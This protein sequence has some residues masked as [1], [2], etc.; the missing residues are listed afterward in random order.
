MKQLHLAH[1]FFTLFLFFSNDASSQSKLPNEFRFPKE[2]KLIKGERGSDADDQYSNGKYI[3]DQQLMF[4]DHEFTRN[5]D[6][7]KNYM[8]HSFGFPFRLTKDGL[9]WGTGKKEGY[10]SY[11]VITSHGTVFELYST[12]NDNGFSSWSVWLLKN[13]RAYEKTGKSAYF[14]TRLR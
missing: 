14:P 12:Y 1:I 9:C 7:V 6:S 2:F 8:S 3:F 11:I 4:V 10:Y 5:D 13:I